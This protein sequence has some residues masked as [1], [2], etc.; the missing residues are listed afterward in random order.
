MSHY[1]K[2]LASD[3][4][5]IR[6]AVH[7]LG[8]RVGKALRNAVDALLTSNR[9]LAYSTIIED[10]PIN[11]QSEELDRS[12]HRFIARHLPSAGHLRFIS[13]VLRMNIQLER[14]GD[15]AVTICREAVRL[16]RPLTGSFRAE[17][18]TMA[19]DAFQMLDQALRALQEQNE[20]LAR[21]TMGYAAQVDRDF[22]LAFNILAN[23]DEEVLTNEELFARLIIITQIERASDQAKNLCEEIVFTVS[24][25]TKKR[26]PVQILMLDQTDSHMTQVA[27][28]LAR[29][30]YPDRAR[31]TSAGSNPAKALDPAAMTFIDKS[32]LDSSG[33][34][35]SSVSWPP[36]RWKDFDVVV[37][38]NSD[39]NHYLDEVPFHTVA[40]RWDIDTGSGSPESWDAA[41]RTLADRLNDLVTTLRGPSN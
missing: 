23:K 37:A 35:P 13:S 26:R 34:D 3:L 16:R 40:L 7:G 11:R 4:E 28:A 27:V 18:E 25:E 2:R 31:I 10:N 15:Y 39:V 33:L 1:E 22:M 9:D 20:E 21:G 30:Y 19:E 29:K 17:V 38:I 8:T 12:C 5:S 32:G 14:M 41:F 6:K 36:E 24:G